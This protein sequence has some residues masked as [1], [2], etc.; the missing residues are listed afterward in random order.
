MLILRLSLLVLSQSSSQTVT[1]PGPGNWSTIDTE[2]FCRHFAGLRSPLCTTCQSAT[3]M[4]NW[5]SELGA[6]RF[7]NFPS[8]SNAAKSPPIFTLPPQ[9]DRLG[10]PIRALGAQ[11]SATTSTSGVATSHPCKLL[12]IC[13][14]C[15]KAHPRHMCSIKQLKAS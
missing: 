1:V 15:H 3:H 8:T 7:P 9:A 12:H 2:L 10:R 4:A 5:C 13:L 6:R 14:A 11:L